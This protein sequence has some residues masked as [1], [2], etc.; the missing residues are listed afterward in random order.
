M[1]AEESRRGR[2]PKAYLRFLS[3]NLPSSGRRIIGNTI[4]EFQLFIHGDRVT[5]LDPDLW[6]TVLASIIFA[7]VFL[8]WVLRKAHNFWQNKNRT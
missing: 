7:G 5:P 2:P 1:A 3:Q 4:V 6:I 8:A